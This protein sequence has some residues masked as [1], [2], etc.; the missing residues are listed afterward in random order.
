MYEAF[1]D[2]ASPRT[3]STK[4]EAINWVEGFVAGE[5][6]DWTRDV[7]VFVKFPRCG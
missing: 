1:V 7:Q 4:D 2:G 6:R 3:F 5:V